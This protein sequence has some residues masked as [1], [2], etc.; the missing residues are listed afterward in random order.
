MLFEVRCSALSS[1]GER[2]HSAKCT[3][4]CVSTDRETA[5]KLALKFLPTRERGHT[6]PYFTWGWSVD[7]VVEVENDSAFQVSGRLTS[8]Q[9]VNLLWLD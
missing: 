3:L 5:E 6:N 1:G 8:S 4:L 2:I 7:R 9:Q